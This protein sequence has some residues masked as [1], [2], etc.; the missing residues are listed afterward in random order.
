[1][2][3]IQPE[4]LETASTILLCVII[5]IVIIILIWEPIASR[6]K[7]WKLKREFKLR[8]KSAQR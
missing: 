3:N 2:K 7:R 8:D 6:I 4:S 1:M 5:G